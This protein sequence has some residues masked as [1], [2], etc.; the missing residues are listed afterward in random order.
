MAEFN[1]IDEPWI[2]CI[3]SSG[4][5][6]EHGIRYTL[7]KAHDLREICDD[8]PLVTV[9]LHRLLLAILYRAHKGPT[10]MREW[11]S[12]YARGS[13][14]PNDGIDQYLKDWCDRFYLF[15]DDHPFMQVAG[16][17]L[18]EYN[19]DGAVKK[20]K[21]DG[22]MRLA[23]EAPDK[24]GRILFD[25]RVGTERPEYELK[26]I[27]KMILS[28]QSFSGTGVASA[29]K[30]GDKRI[31][32]TPCQFAPCVEGLVLWLQGESLF[33][34]LLLNLV[35]GDYDVNDKPAWEDNSIV[36][37]SI[38]SWNK[39]ITFAGPVQRFA[40]VSR[41]LRL[42]DRRSVFFTNGLKAA[43]DSG[44]PM[45]AYSRSDDRQGYQAVKLRADRAAWRDSHTLFSLNSSVRKS[46]ASLN[47][48]A[49]LDGDG[50]LVTTAQPRA[51][52]VGL[53]TDQG[54]ALLWRH[55]RI[56]VPLSILGSNDLTEHLGKLIA[57]AEAI[58]AKLSRGLFWSA[59][60]KKTIRTEPVGR[61]Q[62]IADL[63]L[64]PSLEHERPGVLRTREG[65]ALGDAHNKAALD[66]SESLDPRPSYWSRLEEH[67]YVLLEN[68]PNDWDRATDGWKPDD[69]RAATNAWRSRVKGEARRALQESISSLGTTARA[70]QA[71][72]RVSID[73][74]DDDLMPLP[75]KAA[76][77]KRKGERRKGK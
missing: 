66:L 75:E 16:L 1:L 58:G 63:Y 33:H 70:I 51:N 30:V 10:D 21:S 71:V 36:D 9:A 53:A 39:P 34:T 11:Q 38:N 62:A 19:Q 68:L 22:L 55:E 48:V 24:G 59:T 23:R 27:A 46:P 35:P 61:I 42:V 67:F 72:A 74:Y 12:L 73:F 25:H 13:F 50:I 65:R 26:Q 44:D 31:T 20:D 45:K 60:S 57:E 77:S 56:P 52:V 7:L 28:A 69:Q 17:D 49:R 3:D 41:F 4:Q 40:T 29:G 37:V 64:E 54:K 8:S 5:R 47:H 18:N 2:P 76:K 6:V 15:D 14:A 43:A 32:P